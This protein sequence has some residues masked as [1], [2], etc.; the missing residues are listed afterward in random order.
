MCKR[1]LIR[2]EES[3]GDVFETLVDWNFRWWGIPRGESRAQVR[4]LMAHSVCTDR[5]PQTFVA[6]EGDTPVGMYQLSMT[7]DLYGRPDLYPWLVNVYV[8]E[9]HRGKSVCRFMMEQVGLTARNAG[10][11]SLYLYTSHVGLYEK[12]GWKFVE[13]VPTFQEKSPIERLYRLEL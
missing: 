9:E 6:M 3:E 7:D 5:L 8:P 12:F 11:S 1:G 4:Y 2:L 13:E 10:L